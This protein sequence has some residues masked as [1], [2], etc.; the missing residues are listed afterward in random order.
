M[1]VSHRSSMLLDTVWDVGEAVGSVCNHTHTVSQHV[2][3]YSSTSYSTTEV[4]YYTGYRWLHTNYFHHVE[5][6]CSGIRNTHTVS[7]HVVR[8]SSIHRTA[9]SG[10]IRTNMPHC[11]PPCDASSSMHRLVEW[12]PFWVASEWGNH[13]YQAPFISIGRI[14]KKKKKSII[15]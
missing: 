10:G 9:M 5:V 2:M 12:G 6:R 1:V 14:K 8:H 3:E 11:Y 13:R 15:S 7:K 4:V